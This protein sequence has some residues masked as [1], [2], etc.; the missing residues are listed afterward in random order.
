MLSF[1]SGTIATKS[2]GKTLV[3]YFI[4]LNW[5]HVLKQPFGKSGNDLEE[6][7]KGSLEL[8]FAGEEKQM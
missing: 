5:E 4:Q 8:S 3:S 2:P 1:T 6:L 7:L